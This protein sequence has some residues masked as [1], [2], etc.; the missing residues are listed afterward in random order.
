M[1][2]DFISLYRIAG[3]GVLPVERAE[4]EIVSAA[5][6]LSGLGFSHSDRPRRSATSELT[7]I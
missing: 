5:Q 4:H 2:V 7:Q 6:T 1:R 3:P